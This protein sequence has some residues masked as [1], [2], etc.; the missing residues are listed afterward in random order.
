[1][2]SHPFTPAR[3]SDIFAPAMHDWARVHDQIHIWDY[4]VNFSH[5]TA[6]MPNFE[7]VADNIR[8]FVENNCTGVMLQ[9]AYQ[10]AGAERELMRCWVFGKLLWDPSLDV[11][12]LT[13][14][15]I[16]GYY[17]KAAPAILEYD[18]LLQQAGRDH[19][20]SLAA[21][22]GGIRYPM[23]SEFLSRDFLWRAEGLFDRAEELAENDEIRQRVELARVPIMY[24]NL[25]RGPAF[26]GEGYAALI[27]RFEAIAERE[28]ITHIREGAPDV[29]NKIKKWRDEIRVQA[30]LQQ[31]RESDITILPLSPEWRFAT[32]PKD[33]GTGAKWFAPE[34]DDGAWATV[35][36]DV[37]K[38]WESQGFE[39][40]TGVGWYRQQFTPAKLPAKKHLY[41]FFEAVDEDA[42]VYI[43]GKPAFEHTC[44]STGLPPDQIW[45]TPFM[46]DVKDAF[47]AGKPTSI[48]VRVLNRLGMGGVYKPVRLI[49]S[50]REL[51]A[52][53][54]TRL[55]AEGKEK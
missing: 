8:F 6:P 1:M 51:D 2:W 7:V 29:K 38:G 3:E 18:Q 48:A 11:D 32:D 40:Y 52:T 49:A 20:E 44:N 26:V 36:S 47:K 31:A 19:A 27:D 17:G 42:I 9:G 53:V 16:W 46:F 21:P 14:D 23:D 15:F 45:I 24:V 33:A 5:Y 43:D 12:A 37:D 25:V 22:K 39:D 10:S 30:E 28:S 4:C 34:F 41:L 50:A 55:L 54:V 35:R 13:E